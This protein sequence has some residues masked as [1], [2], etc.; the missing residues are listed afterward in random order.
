M[1][2]VIEIENNCRIPCLVHGEHSG[3]PV[4]RL[5]LFRKHVRTQEVKYRTHVEAGFEVYVDYALCNLFIHV[6]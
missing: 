4:T 5:L 2:A 3:Q 1:V 6:I